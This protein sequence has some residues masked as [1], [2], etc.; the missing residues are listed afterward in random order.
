MQEVHLIKPHII[1]VV[2]IPTLG[3]E[4]IQMTDHTS[5]HIPPFSLYVHRLLLDDVAYYSR[6]PIPTAAKRKKTHPATHLL[7]HVLVLHWDKCMLIY[8]DCQEQAMVQPVLHCTQ[9][10]LI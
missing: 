2:D 6:D 5:I 8:I 7:K 3:H 4:Y 9:V 1:T 10:A